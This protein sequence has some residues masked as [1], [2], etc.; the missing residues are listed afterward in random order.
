[1]GE[2]CTG[3][4]TLLFLSIHIMSKHHS[5]FPSLFREGLFL[6]ILQLLATS[7][8]ASVVGSLEQVRGKVYIMRDSKRQLTEEGTLV[9]E[10]DQIITYR[11]SGVTLKLRD[12]AEIRLFPN[13]YFNII[14]IN[15]RRKG[16]KRRFRSDFK[17]IYGALWG[18]FPSYGHLTTIST[19]SALVKSNGGYL[20]INQ[21]RKKLDIA[22]ERGKAFIE[23]EKEQLLLR[24]G[25]AIRGITTSDAFTKRIESIPYQL[26]MKAQK[27]GSFSSM[28]KNIEQLYFTIQMAQTVGKKN[29][30]QKGVVYLRTNYA[31]VKLPHVEL[32]ARG[33]AHFS[34]QLLRPNQ[35]RYQEEAIKIEAIMEGKDFLDVKKGEITLRL[36]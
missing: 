29:R 2:V 34:T 18:E 22:V 15:E 10:K 20:R 16:K 23:N 35:D 32:N 33:F 13:S 17:L 25:E 5:F 9:H 21:S 30:H 36:N 3:K 12:G 31:A 7:A 6:L 28:G 4:W 27:R 11:N 1:M 8:S 24:S 14:N 19:N 26:V